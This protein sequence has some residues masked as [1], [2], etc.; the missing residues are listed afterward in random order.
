MQ[1]NSQAYRRTDSALEKAFVYKIGSNTMFVDKEYN[2]LPTLENYEGLQE[3]YTNS[4]LKDFPF[5][6]I[7]VYDVGTLDYIEGLKL[8]IIERDFLNLEGLYIFLTEQCFHTTGHIQDL[9]ADGTSRYNLDA[10]EGDYWSPELESVENFVKLNKLTNVTVYTS[11]EDPKQV[12][13]DTYSFE[14]KREDATLNAL[15]NR[16][17]KLEKD[18]IGAKIDKK[19]WCGNWRYEPHRHI[20]TAFASQL[21]TEYSWYYRDNEHCVLENIWFD[22]NELKHKHQVVEGIYYLNE[23][24]KG[25]DIQSDP[26]DISGTI[27]DKFI[28][29]SGTKMSGP[30]LE[31]Y[32][33]ENLYGNTFC[34]IV[35]YSTF[36]EPFPS[37]DEKVLNAM[38]NRRP[39]VFCG[40][41]GSLQLMR[42][43]G[44]KTFG[45]FWDE[46]YD[47]EWDHTK[48]LEM[49]FDLLQEINSWSIEQCQQKYVEMLEVVNHN[50]MWLKEM[51]IQDYEMRRTI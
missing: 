49:I 30:V 15:T 19:F 24:T 44:F 46:S 51:D 36:N 5:S 28:R 22:I 33:N 45:N 8:G 6:F 34:S 11:F 39:F 41:P 12:Y 14:I 16:F 37:Y 26:V 48:R 29:P 1:S 2:V 50:Y 4:Y 13:K 35:N 3:I 32:T 17:K 18:F 43:D 31:E 21:D 7:Q 38:I 10:T 40:P 42:K 25:I 20:I 23:N 9:I 27:E 47:T